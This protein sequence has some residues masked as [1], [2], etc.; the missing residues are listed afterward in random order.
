M[1]AELFSDMLHPEASPPEYWK[2]TR[3]T[4]LY[5]K[6][7][8]DD[9]ANYR[10]VSLLPILSKLFARALFDTIGIRIGYPR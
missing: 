3:S 4:V 1:V 7:E 9:P 8:S 6:G 2:E 10:P 5:Q